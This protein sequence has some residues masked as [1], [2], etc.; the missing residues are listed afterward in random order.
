M[1]RV[2]VI[3]VDGFE[4]SLLESWMDYLPC[5]RWLST[6]GLYARLRSTIPPFTVPAWNS[7]F[8]GVNPGRHGLYGWFKVKFTQENLSLEISTSNKQK[9]PFLWDELSRRGLKVGIVNVPVVYPPMKVNGVVVS[10]L[11]TPPGACYTYP[12]SLM[13][14]INRLLGHEYKILSPMM[15]IEAQK[16]LLVDRVR[17]SL[18]LMKKFDWS[19]FIVVFYILDAIQ[20]T[21]WHTLQSKSCKDKAKS[22][23]VIRDFYIF[24]DRLIGFLIRKVPENTSIIL[25]SD[26][27]FGP[28]KE[29]FNVNNW[30]LKRGLL[31]LDVDVSKGKTL[32]RIAGPPIKTA[33]RHHF[34]V[35]RIL[36]LIPDRVKWKLRHL[37]RLEQ[38][39]SYICEHIDCNQSLAI[40]VG[41]MGE[42]YIRSDVS[43][44]ERESL[45][46]KI[47]D[48]LKMARLIG[49]KRELRIY[50][51][52]KVYRGLYVRQAPDVL[53]SMDELRCN[54]KTLIG[55]GL[56]QQSLQSGGHRMKGVL[57]VKPPREN[58]NFTRRGEAS[59]YDVTPTI[60][61]LLNVSPKVTYDGSPLID[62]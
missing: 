21:H 4:P 24:I 10:G 17:V 41:E 6:R 11:L 30:L 32:S 46:N 12:Q 55:T 7:M 57:I 42:I 61:K 15:S 20:H 19:L 54:Q 53:Y 26:H 56:F 39:M 28:L 60:M 44:R 35:S 3:G 1:E 5:I 13:N 59:I 29:Y 40:G 52:E 49:R 58:L 9:F 36:S 34:L 48:G 18:Y 16:S 43:R 22:K 62:Y 31:K 2:L 38:G 45:I 51:R 27:G 14:E 50:R 23:C 47:I 25:V 8:T 33:V 37:S